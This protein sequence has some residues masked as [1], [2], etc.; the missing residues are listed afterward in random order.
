MKRLFVFALVFVCLGALAPSVA[1]AGVEPSP[2]LP[3]GLAMDMWTPPGQLDAFNPQPEPPAFSVKAQWFAFDPQPEPPGKAREL[4]TAPGKI[5]GF[6]PQ[7]EP[8]G[9]TPNMQMIIVLY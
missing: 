1:I 3:P 7:P 4:W 5:V 2:F 9:H 8:P 6:D